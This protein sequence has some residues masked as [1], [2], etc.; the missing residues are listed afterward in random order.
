MP[1][2]SS[3]AKAARTGHNSDTAEAAPQFR[4]E[5][6]KAAKAMHLI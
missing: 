1:A 2:S 4:D 6:T 3:P 5:L